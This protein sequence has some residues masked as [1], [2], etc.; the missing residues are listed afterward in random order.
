MSNEKWRSDGVKSRH[1]YSLKN[2]KHFPK[3]G[4]LLS[5]GQ[6]SQTA[7]VCSFRDIWEELFNLYTTKCTRISWLQIRAIFFRLPTIRQ[8]H[9]V[10][11][12]TRCIIFL[13]RFTVAFNQSSSSRKKSF[14]LLTDTYTIFITEISLTSIFVLS[15]NSIILNLFIDQEP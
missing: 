15:I 2:N 9:F 12:C 8:I 14:H 13:F 4:K 7:D 10:Q 6:E 5:G 1:H 3:D 11:I